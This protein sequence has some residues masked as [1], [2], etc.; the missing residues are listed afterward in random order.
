MKVGE[1]LV[2]KGQKITPFEVGLLATVGI[3]EVLCYSKPVVGIMSTGRL[4]F[5]SYNLYL[6]LSKS[7]PSIDIVPYNLYLLILS[8]AKTK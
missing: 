3:T 6:G 5:I 2:K 7:R 1:L 8:T 4:Y